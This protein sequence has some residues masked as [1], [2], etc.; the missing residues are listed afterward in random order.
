MSDVATIITAAFAGAAAI[1][2]PAGAAI[3]YLLTY[4]RTRR[5]DALAETHE[6]IRSERENNL[7]LVKRLDSIQLATTAELQ[8]KQDQINQ[9]I[10]ERAEL[11]AN[12]C[13]FAEHCALRPNPKPEPENGFNI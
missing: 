12:A 8:K 13:D 1:M 2:V 4:A 11:R 6:I 10:E 7:L 9:L 5:A 3:A